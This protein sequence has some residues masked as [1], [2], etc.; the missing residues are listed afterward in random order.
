MARKKSTNDYAPTRIKD[1]KF[2]R[3]ARE[4]YKAADDADNKQA[5]REKEDIKFEAGEQWS[6]EALA[7]RKGYAASGNMPAIPERPSLVINK[8]KEPVRQILNQERQSDIGI[9]LVPADDFGDLGIT[10]D[11]T[12]VTL[13]EG[14]T[15]RIQRASEAADARTW[16]FKRA[17]I[18]GRGFYRVMTRFLP[19]KSWD[20]EIYVERIFNQSSVKLD[21][22]HEQPDGSD[23]DWGFIGSWMSWDRFGSE[24][25]YLA[26]GSANP[27]KGGSKEDFVSLSEEY[28]DWF[29]ADGEHGERKSVRITEYWYTEYEPRKVALLED[30]SAVWADELPEGT[31]AVDT[32]TVLEKQIKFCKIAGGCLELEKTDWAGPD[33]PIVKV[34]GDEVLPDAGERRAEGVVRP[35]RGAQVGENYMISKFVETVGLTPI[36]SLM[37]DPE[38][39]EGYE[40]WYAVSNVRALPYLPYSSWKDGKQ[41]APPTRPNVDPNI[42]P[43]ANGIAMFDQFIKSTTAVPD[44]TLGNVDPALKSGKAIREVVANAQ[45][46]TSNFMDNLARSIRYE[47]QIINNLLYPIYGAKPGRLV[48]IMTGEGESQM[49]RITDPEQQQAAEAEQAKAEKVGKLTKDAHFNVI[50]KITKSSESRRDQ[51][52]RMFGDILSADP[53]QMMIGGDLFYKNMDIPEAKEL[54][55]RQRLMLAPPI[56]QHL[57]QLEEGSEPIPPAAQ[58]QMAKMAEQIKAAEAALAE[59]ME[60]AKGKQ[61]DNQTKLEVERLKLEADAA[62]EQYRAQTELEKARMENAT[63]IHIAEIAARTK[64][65]VMAHEAEHE[66]AAMQHETEIKAAE[67]MHDEI[68]NEKDR[69]AEML[70]A[71]PSDGAV[72]A[73]DRMGS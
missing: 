37:V 68:E 6:S 24:Y 67:I 7:G 47:G 63:R 72:D 5:E 50:V 19:G 59:A 2:L 35:A 73:E 11:E 17:V 20:Q 61:A 39:I 1:T 25:P 66:A 41:F 26:D 51:F 15:R 10:P 43:M 14:L 21:P 12:E 42:L 58:Q 30:G 32:R 36:A 9:E 3:T 4:R 48:R 60:M 31:E 38:A 70:A 29:M 46:S 44:S 49:M 22:A 71:P 52:V 8:I 28:P 33:M 53:A 27:F 65:V 23:A 16:A 34:L 13:R 18:A 64:G 45:M 56:Q 54:S 40:S 57:A 62:K 55:K 69:V